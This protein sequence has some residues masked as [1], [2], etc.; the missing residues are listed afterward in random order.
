MVKAVAHHSHAPTD[1]VFRVFSLISLVFAVVML[2]APE[3]FIHDSFV[4]AA[5]ASRRPLVA[6]TRELSRCAR[7]LHTLTLTARKFLPLVLVL[8]F[9]FNLLCNECV[10]S[11]RSD[12][13]KYR[14][15]LAFLFMVRVMGVFH[16][17]TG[18]LL[19][20]AAT[21]SDVLDK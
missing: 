7:A 21:F 14:T 10:V 19:G 17:F 11:W 3:T 16:L 12:V 8:N 1:T 2:F 9:I 18:N 13:K 4:T 6:H 15:D 5:S 20:Y